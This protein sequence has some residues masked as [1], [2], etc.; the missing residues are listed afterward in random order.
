MGGCVGGGDGHG[1]TMNRFWFQS[2]GWPDEEEEEEEEEVGCTRSVQLLPSLDTATARP[3]PH[4][5]AP[6]PPPP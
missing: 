1:G 2:A 6:L 3:P 5:L 4:M